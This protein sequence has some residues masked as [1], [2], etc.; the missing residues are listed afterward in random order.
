VLYQSKKNVLVTL[1]P[2]GEEYPRAP[3]HKLRLTASEFEAG[4]AFTPR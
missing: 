2:W 3:G 4:P 1:E